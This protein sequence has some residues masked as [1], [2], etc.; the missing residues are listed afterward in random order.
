MDESAASCRDSTTRLAAIGPFDQT[1][2]ERYLL[3]DPS[4]ESHLPESLVFDMAAGAP[5]NFKFYSLC[6][7]PNTGPPTCGVVDPALSRFAISDASADVEHVRFLV[8][9]NNV[10][11]TRVTLTR[12]RPPL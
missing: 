12:I 5:T 11:F 8:N 4:Q 2:L 9:R 7:P 10:E 6:V 3:V 1:G